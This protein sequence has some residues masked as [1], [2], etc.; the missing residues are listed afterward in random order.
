M[1]SQAETQ[2]NRW[3]TVGRFRR[4]HYDNRTELSWLCRST[5]GSESTHIAGGGGGSGIGCQTDHGLQRLIVGR[6]F[7]QLDNVKRL[8]ALA[9]IK[10]TLNFGPP[11]MNLP[12]MEGCP[13]SRDDLV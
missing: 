1:I 11:V 2:P 13:I 12:S 9:L 5:A 6:C 4:G 7:D 10:C 8:E 3:Q